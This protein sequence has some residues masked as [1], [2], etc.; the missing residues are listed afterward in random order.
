LLLQ[1]DVAKEIATVDSLSPEAAMAT[2][3]LAQHSRLNIVELELS[4]LIGE[5]SDD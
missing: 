4:V 1:K 5:F 2:R 3:R